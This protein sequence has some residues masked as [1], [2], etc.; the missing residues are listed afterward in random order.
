[1]DESC[2]SAF[3]SVSLY[4]RPGAET[5]NA[6]VKCGHRRLCSGEKS[7]VVGIPDAGHIVGWCYG[8]SD[9]V[10][11]H[12]PYDRFGTEVEEKGGEW[13]ALEGAT[14]YAYGGVG[15]WGV[16]KIVVADV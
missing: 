6:E 15:P 10:V 9:S 5:V 7:C 1:M 3:G 14:L 8:A 2:N 16:R 11:L 13:V 12:P 4:A